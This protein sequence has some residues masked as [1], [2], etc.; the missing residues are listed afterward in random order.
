VQEHCEEGI[1][2][3]AYLLE[4]EWYTKEIVVSYLVCKRYGKQECHV[5]ENREQEVVSKRQLEELKWCG[6]PKKEK[7][8][9]ACSTEGN[10]QQDST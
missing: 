6:C 10:A 4:L 2:N 7:R 8:K 1:P 9:V 5:E 3:E